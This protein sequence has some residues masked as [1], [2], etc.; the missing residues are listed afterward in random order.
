MKILIT[1]AFGNLGTQITK[2]AIAAGHEVT[3]ADK[4]CKPIEGID[5]ARYT[6][7]GIDV[8]KPET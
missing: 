7:R 5:P 6:T 3:A 8:T 2:A 4:V 1:G